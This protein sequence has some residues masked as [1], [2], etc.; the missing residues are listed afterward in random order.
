MNIVFL[1]QSTRTS[2][3]GLRFLQAMNESKFELC[4]NFKILK[5]KSIEKPY[6]FID[7]CRFPW[8]F[9]ADFF[10]RFEILGHHFDWNSGNS[11]CVTTKTFFCSTPSSIYSCSIGHILEHDFFCLGHLGCAG[12][13]GKKVDLRNSE[14]LLRVVFSTFWGQNKFLKIF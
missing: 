7:E 6:L 2:S 5:S 3:A 4:P 9:D 10:Y 14:Q 12:S 8:T 13:Q 1:E 11:D